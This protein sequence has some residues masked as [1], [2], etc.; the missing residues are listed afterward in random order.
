MD[1]S[2]LVSGSVITKKS[3]VS[4]LNLIE[5]LSVKYQTVCQ[6]KNLKFSKHVSIAREHTIINIDAH[7]LDKALNHLL[8]NAVKF[9]HAGSVTI[10]VSDSADEFEFFVADTGSGIDITA[11]SLVFDYFRQEEVASTRGYEG[12]GLGLSIAKGLTELLGGKIRL[13]SEKGKGSVF[14]LTFPKGTEAYEG[15]GSSAKTV[16]KVKTKNTPVILVV[17]DDESNSLLLKTILEKSSFHC[18]LA[19][20]G[21]EAVDICIE[22]P[23]VALVLMDLKMPVMDGYEATRRIKELRKSLP[24]IGVTAFAMTGDKVKALEAGCDEYLAKPVKSEVLMAV[25]RKYLG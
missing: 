23:D 4:P 17:D 11:Q 18:L 21:E 19:Y 14:Y 15:T 12:S 24:V 9:T 7:L 20:N 8:D 10:G 6:R 25:I 2:L 22:S 1:I 16:N 3:T 5:N 13:E